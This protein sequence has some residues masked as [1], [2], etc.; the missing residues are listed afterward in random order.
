MKVALFFFSFVLVS[1]GGFAQQFPPPPVVPDEEWVDKVYMEGVPSDSQQGTVEMVEHGI[2]A[3]QLDRINLDVE[4]TALNMEEFQKAVEY[5]QAAKD[6]GISGIVEV[7][8]H[9]NEKGEYLDHQIMTGPKPILDE[10][11]ESKVPMLR[12]TPGM[13]KEKPVAC[14]V[15]VVV[16]Y[17]LD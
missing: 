10:L 7:R 14:W 11:V 2:D 13:E 15:F 12:F 5:P 8:I 9:I 16:P 1:A 4:P 3:E 6:A 17:F